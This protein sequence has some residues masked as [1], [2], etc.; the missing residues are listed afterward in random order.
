[1]IFTET[2]IAHVRDP[3]LLGLVNAAPSAKTFDVHNPSNGALLATLRDM[4]ITETRA[5][6]DDA[7]AAQF[8]W[9]E[10]P[11]GDRSTILRRWHDLVIAILTISP[12]S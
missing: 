12:R 10:R 3:H 11:A 8:P 7:Y 5:A 4:G 6:I 2:L 1:M 9:A